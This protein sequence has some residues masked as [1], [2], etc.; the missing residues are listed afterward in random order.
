MFKHRRLLS[1]FKKNNIYFLSTSYIYEKILIK[2]T[3]PLRKTE[4]AVFRQ[5]MDEKRNKL[6]R[7]VSHGDL[8]TLRELV[9]KL[10]NHV[11]LICFVYAKT[12]D[13]AVHIAVEN[14]HLSVL[15]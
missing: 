6:L 8:T 2:K 9:S 12:G 14:G 10:K 4:T 7:A 5:N 11:D 13:S 3:E 15:K 1:F